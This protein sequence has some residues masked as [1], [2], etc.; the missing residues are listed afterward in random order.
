[1]KTSSIPNFF[2]ESTQHLFAQYQAVGDGMLEELIS[3]TPRPAEMKEDAYRRTLKARAFDMAR[4]LLPLATKH[5]R[6]VR[7]RMARTLEQQISRLLTS[8]Y[9]GDP[10]PWRAVTGGC[11]RALPGTSRTRQAKTL[12]DEI[13]QLDP[14]LAQRAH[15]HLLREGPYIAHAG[16]VHSTLGVRASQQGRA[17]AGCA[18]THGQAA[19]IAAATSRR[20]HRDTQERTP[21]P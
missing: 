15:E 4:Y 1:L 6:S 19:A 11:R 2:T 12:H 8:E 18:T 13:A 17:L 16:Q 10:R 14:A 9:R 7:S 21:H 5:P 20:S 3:A